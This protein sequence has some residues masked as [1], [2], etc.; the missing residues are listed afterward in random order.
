MRILA[1]VVALAA[2]TPN[3]GGVASPTPGAGPSPLPAAVML[4]PGEQMVWE[5][6]WQGLSIGRAHLAVAGNQVTASFA[7]GRMA[8]AVANVH[9]DLATTLVDRTARRAIEQVDVRGDADHTDVAIDGAHYTIRGGTRGEVPG[10]SPLHTLT[11]ALGAVRAWAS[12]SATRAYAWVIIDGALYR[13]DVDPP[14][15]ESLDGIRALRVEGVV[16]ALDPKGD[17]AEVTLWLAD[18]ADR[19]PLRVAVI[20]RGERVVAQ[21]SESTATFAAR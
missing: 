17:A 14:V 5:V 4:E 1:L 10:G 20:A 19:T 13:L 2:C 3:A 6:F 21:L 11:S 18:R 15:H 9:Y 12:P 7:T 8:R 16:R